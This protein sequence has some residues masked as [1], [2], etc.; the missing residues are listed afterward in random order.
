MTWLFSGA[1]IYACIVLAVYVFQDKLLF[2][3]AT[4]GR[5]A[6]LPEI[7]GVAV[8]RLALPSSNTQ[9]RSKTFRI[10]WAEPRDAAQARGVI[11]FFLGNGEDL[12]SGVNWAK[13]WTEYQLCALVVEYPGYGESDGRASLKSILQAAEI[14]GL[15]AA[16]RAKQRKLPLFAGGTSLGTFSA[17]HL[18]ASDLPVTRLLLSAPP[19][20]MLA[21]AR[22]R[23]WWLPVAWLLRHRFDNLSLAKQIKI[24]TLV[25]HGD[26]DRVVPESMGRELA[27]AFAGPC[28]F[29]EA[30]AC[31]HWIPLEH[32][33]RF[34]EPI[35]DFLFTQR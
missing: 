32:S 14:A 12:R 11:V 28:R 1:A 30:A 24:P 29:L 25:L 5:G 4:A 7:A 31:G 20:T 13:G 34:G 2:V 23:F 17:V 33:G 6:K 8:E 10:A 16:Q 19:T 26:R 18:A 27:A 15:E 35:R 21:A 9:A 3:G 22:L